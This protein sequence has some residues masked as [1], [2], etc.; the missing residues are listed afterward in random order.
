MEQSQHLGNI[1]FYQNLVVDSDGVYASK[2]W[3]IAVIQGYGVNNCLVTE[4]S[5][6]HCPPKAQLLSEGCIIWLNSS[7]V[8]CS[9]PAPNRRGRLRH[10]RSLVVIW[11]VMVQANISLQKDC[12]VMLENLS[13]S[14]Q[15]HC[16]S[17]YQ[18]QWGIMGWYKKC[19]SQN[20]SDNVISDQLKTISVQKISTKYGIFHISKYKVNEWCRPKF[21]LP[22]S[23]YKNILMV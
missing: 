21:I 13:K 5:P 10:G 7:L 17:Q 16:Y 6:S 8:T 1:K 2:T 18:L 23:L 9:L 14:L 22:I 3:A 20:L 4:M 19:E 11:C 15:K 12:I